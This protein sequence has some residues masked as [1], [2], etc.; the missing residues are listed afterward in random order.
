MFTR[1]V[2][3][4][5]SLELN[6]KFVS[7]VRQRRW[8]VPSWCMC[9]QAPPLPISPSPRT[10]FDVSWMCEG[11]RRNRGMRKYEMEMSVHGLRRLPFRLARNRQGFHSHC[12]QT[13][14]VHLSK[15]ILVQPRAATCRTSS[16]RNLQGN[17]V[18]A[19]FLPRVGLSWRSCTFW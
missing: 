4:S 10:L 7:V 3:Q 19:H 16:V 15:F 6:V 8:D 11:G 18:L 14:T 2:C 5:A 17:T 13:H 12:F 1:A 9:C